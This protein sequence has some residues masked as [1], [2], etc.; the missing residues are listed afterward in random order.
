[1]QN[2]MSRTIQTTPGTIAVL[3]STTAS[4]RPAEESMDDAQLIGALG[5]MY[6]IQHVLILFNGSCSL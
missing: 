4:R 6:V 5:D 3:G 1:M 2:P